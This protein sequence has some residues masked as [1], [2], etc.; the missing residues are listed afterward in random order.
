M[1]RWMLRDLA[2]AL[3]LNFEMNVVIRTDASRTI[4]TGHVMRC[5]SLAEA[6]ERRGASVQF[7]CRKLDG[8]LGEYI[9]QRGFVVNMLATAAAGPAAR[10]SS[11]YSPWLGVRWQDDAED[12]QA[13]IAAL[14]S[15]PDWL[16]AD[17]YALDK[18][19]E[20]RCR[21]SSR[22]TM[23]IDDLANREHDCD[24]LLDQNLYEDA[25]SRYGGKLPKHCQLLL[26]PQFALL[27][28]D[29]AKARA[30]INERHGVVRRILVF[31]GGT[32][33]GNLTATSV[34][35]LKKLALPNV[36]VDVIIGEK[37]QNR[38]E[39][40]AA[41]CAQN[42]ACHVQTNQ[43]AELMA[44]ADLAIGAGGSASWERCCVGLPCLTFAVARNQQQLVADAAMGGILYAP[45]VD[46]SDE[47]AIARHVTA[48]VQN[49]MLL[50]AMS[51]RAM[52][53]V[54]G[55]GC[56][57]VARA[58]GI[59][60][61]SVHQATHNDSE[62]IFSWRNHPHVREV[63]RDTE[64]L[65]RS[66]HQ[67]WFDEVL[68]DSNRPLLIAELEDE[69]VGVVRFDINAEIAEVSIYLAPDKSQRGLGTELL[70]AAEHWLAT[71]R[72]DVIELRA[73]VMGQNLSSQRVF[74]N[75][76][77]SGASTT[78]FKRIQ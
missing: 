56:D 19:W 58:L 11:D 7:I 31:F 65:Q 39:I 15:K 42:F 44:N 13:A 32:D 57:R 55:R 10:E 50:Q 34:A 37:Y 74:L 4:G 51:K 21:E 47:D 69:P 16:V 73:E 29:F 75:S 62:R 68:E 71:M 76:G 53:L 59:F 72:P 5:L 9:K 18:R 67:K 64:P 17:H 24:L 6:L 45:S 63:S 77:Y 46:P 43:M 66:A 33:P 3:D 27:R 41:C 28:S 52:A 61:V 78:L 22:R 35:A 38:L 23:A 48:C 40:E 49:P 12:T 70:Q 14:D 8:H 26:G 2:V 20:G 36:A 25:T 60:S 54:D 1:W 30:S